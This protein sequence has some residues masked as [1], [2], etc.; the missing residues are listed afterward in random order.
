[1]KKKYQILPA[2]GNPCRDCSK[3]AIG[4]HSSCAIYQ[5]WKQ[6]YEDLKSKSHDMVGEYE[7]VKIFRKKKQEL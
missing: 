4:C 2:N 7:A 3:R 5:T 6:K 1:M